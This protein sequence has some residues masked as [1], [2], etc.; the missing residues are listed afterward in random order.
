MK[1]K[2]TDIEQL[3]RR[4]YG[5]MFRLARCFLYDTDECKDVVSEVFSHLL[6]V[7]VRLLPESE[8]RY[9]MQCVRNRCMNVI[10]HKSIKERAAAL[11]LNEQEPADAENDNARLDRLLQIIQQIEPPIRRQILSMRHLQGMSYQG[12]ADET[13]I[14]KVTVYRHLLQAVEI[15]RKQFKQA[16]L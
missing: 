14:S 6:E 12:I 11:L 13:G 10:E 15:V 7:P 3:F 1:Q 8:E 2:S 5:K 4:Y 16:S 9:L